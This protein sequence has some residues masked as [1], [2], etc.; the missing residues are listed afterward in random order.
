MILELM[1]SRRSV[2]RFRPEVPARELVEQV[3]EAA[4][5]APSASNRQPWRF[6]AVADRQVIARMADA[7]RAAVGRIAQHIEPSFETSFRNY[8]RYFTRFE[9]AP[10]VLAPLFRGS[11]LL[12]DMVDDQLPPEDRQRIEILERD[13]GLIGAS[14]ALQNLLL[15]AHQLG[16]GASGMTG[17]LVASHRLRE[18]LEIPTSWSV[19]ALVPLGFPDEEPTPTRRKPV[20]KVLRWI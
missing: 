14:L 15:A 1:K 18:I 13:S 19:V 7:V 12:S 17:P 16:L 5:T 11:T 6:L 4:I 20:A 2:R 8:G 9:D 3:I 10:I